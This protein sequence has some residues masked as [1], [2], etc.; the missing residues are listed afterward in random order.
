MIGVGVLE[1]AEGSVAYVLV[2]ILAAIPWIELLL[3]IPVGVA[4][5]LNPLA[6]AVL[7][8]TGNLATV[9]LLVFA[10]DSLSS[11]WKKF[12]LNDNDTEPEGRKRRA[13]RT[14]DTYGLPGLAM[15]API[16]TGTHLAALIALSLGSRKYSVI[17]WMSLSIL[18]WTVVV[19]IISYY[20]IES[21]K[22]FLG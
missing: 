11:F 6:V 16:A 22:W 20:G 14:W 2:F 19:T 5:G 8:A 12:R 18:L 9:Y 7:A 13:M 21:L 4:I 10:H 15:I 17:L 3:V 1:N